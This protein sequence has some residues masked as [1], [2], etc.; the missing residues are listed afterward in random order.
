MTRT[1]RFRKPF[2]A[3]AQATVV[4][5][6]S[7]WA[8]GQA[9]DQQLALVY[10]ALQ[11]HDFTQAL[12][13][14]QPLLQQSPGNAQLWAMQGTAYAG[15]DRKK[16]AL[17]SW[18][19]ALKISP[20]YLPALQGAAQIEY[21]NASP[22]AMPLIQRILK[23]RPGDATSQGM[24]AVLEY[25]RGNCADAVRHFEKSGS[26][27]D[28]RPAGLHAYAIC[29]TRVKQFDLAEK[30]FRRAI[31][32]DPDSPQ[33]RRVLAALQLMDNK[34]SEA[35]TTLQP[36]LQA[37]NPDAATLELASRAHENNKDT[38]KAVNLLRQAILTDPQ[39]VNLYLDFANLS[40]A[41]DSF[42]VGVDVIGDGLA[43]QPK[44][45][46][47]YFARGVLLVQLAQYDKA[48]VDFQRAYELDPNQ[49][50]S[51]AAQGLAAAQKNDYDSALAKVKASLARKPN[52]AFM[53]YLQADILAAKN[54]DPGTP[55]FEL[56]VRSARKA[57]ELKPT[58][59]PARSVLAKLDLEAG[60]YK[61]AA[62][63]CRKAL[64]LDPKDQT[65]VYHLIQALRKSGDTGEIPGLLK[66]LAVLR[67][68][69]A[70]ET[71]DR[72]RYQLVEGDTAQ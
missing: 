72:N 54:I 70:K 22:I 27:F 42:Q 44:A 45:A 6:S 36:L 3:F 39:N 34:P 43:L 33:E 64:E 53:L 37:K 29:L 10:S 66:R 51:S 48:E 52:D 59:A 21:D 55:D 1:L 65:S 11:N 16:E 28:S 24:L 31:A 56:A 49:S 50:L 20:D 7:L 9:A 12:E 18:E 69:A 61:E 15:E 13:L 30:V 71:G 68:E 40:Y 62:D 4:F 19:Q 46:S 25:Q 35:L 5:F 32:L 17:A 67:H 14:L 8:I 26:L 63:Q 60:K 47:L 57:V 2:C 58:L 38:D 23:L 41:H